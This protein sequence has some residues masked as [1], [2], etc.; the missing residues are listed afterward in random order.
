MVAKTPNPK[1][2]HKVS[3]AITMEAPLEPILS[4][5]RRASRKG[6]EADCRGGSSRPSIHRHIHI[7]TYIHI[8]IYT[9]IHIYT[10]TYTY[11]TD[12]YTYIRIYD[13]VYICILFW[14]RALVRRYMEIRMDV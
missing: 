9:Y 6:P 3:W 2:P 8:Y 12:T 4:A 11:H 5:L 7:Y 1:L 10:Y 14:L 13:H